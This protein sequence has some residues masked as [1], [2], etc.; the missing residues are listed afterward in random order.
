MLMTP[1]L[2]LLN[3]DLEAPQLLF[4]DLGEVAVFSHRCPGSEDQNED[5]ALILSIKD[6][7]V[8]A[9]AD[10]AGGGPDGHR[11]SCLAIEA[12]KECVAQGGESVRSAILDAFELA[13]QRVL[14]LGNGAGTTLSVVEIQKG[15]GGPVLRSY[16]AGDSGVLVTG[17]RGRVKLNTIP[18]SPVGYGVEAG[19]IEPAEAI[20]HDD[21]NLVSNLVGIVDMRIEMGSPLAL[22][23]LDAVVLGTDGL[24]DNL[25]LYEVADQARQGRLSDVSKNLVA[26]STR[27]MVEPSEGDPSKPDDVAFIVFRPRSKM[28]TAAKS[29]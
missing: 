12:L 28:G 4:S 17:G 26:L 29:V 18:H 8:L 14:G 5:S 10:G 23:R 19:L 7:L 2:F 6:G 3:E 11:A 1:S 27:R 20:H 24:F 15:A 9:V 25:H 16:H 22:S 21:L 13:N